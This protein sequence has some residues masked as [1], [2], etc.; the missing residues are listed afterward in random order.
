MSIDAN[1]A[2][3]YP[4][5]EP[6][7]P[8]ERNPARAVCSTRQQDAGVFPG[9]E[10][11]ARGADRHH[12]SEIVPVAVVTVKAALATGYRDG[13][14]PARNARELHA[15]DFRPIGGMSFAMT[16]EMPILSVAATV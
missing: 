2:P 7:M 6:K 14:S 16:S 3:A 10:D 5:D 15:Q 12:M 13:E 4:F 11:G 1:S 9:R 8:G